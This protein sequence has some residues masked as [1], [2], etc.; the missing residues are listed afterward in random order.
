MKYPVQ[1]KCGNFDVRACPFLKQYSQS[2][3]GEAEVC[4]HEASEDNFAFKWT[5]LWEPQ[6]ALKQSCVLVK[7]AT[8]LTQNHKLQ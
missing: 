3:P 1:S 6:A 7:E 2:S 5:A 4:L 8:C